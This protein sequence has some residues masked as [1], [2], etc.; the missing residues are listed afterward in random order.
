MSL[1]IQEIRE[2]QVSVSLIPHTFA[3]TRF[4]RLGV[5]DWVNVEVDPVAKQINQQISAVERCV[6]TKAFLME[7]GYM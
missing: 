5:G 4:C 3:N 2:E 7:H 1:T 6:I